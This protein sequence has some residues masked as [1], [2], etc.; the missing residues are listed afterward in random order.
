MW[1]SG[2]GRFVCKQTGLIRIHVNSANLKLHHRR[3]F[4][5]LWEWLSTPNVHLST[6]NVDKEVGRQM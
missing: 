4:I 6:A 5:S 3:N 1:S 2:T